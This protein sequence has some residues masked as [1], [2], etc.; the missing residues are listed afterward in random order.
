MTKPE[1]TPAPTSGRAVYGFCL[2][3]LINTLFI[4]YIFWAFIP[5]K[6]LENQLGLNYLPDKYFALYIPILI[7][8]GTTI[9]AFFIYPS[10]SLSITPDIDS[11]CTIRDKYTIYRCQFYDI[12]GKKCNNKVTSKSL[13]SNKIERE[14]ESSSEGKLQQRSWSIPK[15]CE[16]HNEYLNGRL[17]EFN[18][19]EE[20]TNFCDCTMKKSCLLH[21]NPNFINNLK[22]RPKIPTICDL[23][24]AEICNKIFD[25]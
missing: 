2:F 20:I 9:F 6:I 7:L 10:L 13:I 21:Q 24:L 14:K 12:D 8:C 18:E 22:N 17:N 16:Y 3:L 15:Y 1:H 25:N 23:D 5:T 19:N 4:I 11:E